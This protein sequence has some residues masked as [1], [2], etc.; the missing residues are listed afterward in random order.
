M[1]QILLLAV[2]FSLACVGMVITGNLIV[3]GLL[4]NKRFVR[5]YVKEIADA[6]TEATMEEIES[7][8]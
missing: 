2:L 1:W 4:G 7:R 6:V 5:L 8:Q 3:L